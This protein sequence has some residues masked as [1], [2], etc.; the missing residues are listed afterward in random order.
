MLE[1]ELGI[2][3]TTVENIPEGPDAER[4]FEELAQKNDIIFGTSFGYMDPM[5]NVAQ[6]HPK[7]TFLHATGYKT[8]A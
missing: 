5:Y 1:K 6:K 3:A 7:V 8:A 4:V 2:K